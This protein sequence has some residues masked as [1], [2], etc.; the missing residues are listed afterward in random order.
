[1]QVLEFT[2]E[3]P[4]LNRRAGHCSDDCSLFVLQ[5]RSGIENQC[6]FR[7]RLMLKKLSRRQTPSGLIRASDY[8]DAENGIAAES[9]EVVVDT[10]LLEPKHFRPDAG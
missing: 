10:H 2:L 9:K 6:E 3:E 7:D 1:M 4:V 5:S 8:L